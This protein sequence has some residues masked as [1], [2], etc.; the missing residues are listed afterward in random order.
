MKKCFVIQPFDN[1]KYDSRYSETFKPAIKNAGYYAYR[2]DEDPSV[3]VPIQDIEMGI[4]NSAICFAEISTDNPNVWY[5]LG[6]AFACNKQVIMVSCSEERPGKF[7]FD[8]QHKKVI[9]YSNSS[10]GSYEKLGE[11]IKEAIIAIDTKIEIVNPASTVLTK[12]NFN[13]ESI[14]ITILVFIIENCITTDHFVYLDKLVDYMEKLGY[15]KMETNIAFRSLKN[16]RMI[17]FV[18]QHDTWGNPVD[19]HECVLTPQ[20]ENWILS[21]QQQLKHK[22]H[23][24]ID[25]KNNDDI[26]F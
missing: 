4:M 6:Y 16:K 9:S 3:T 17:D 14:E 8:I 11:K 12:E 23:D 2:V 10:K 5:E 19:N 20:G 21:N 18:K 7:P 26:P 1:S 25:N 15:S 24:V 22:R 13:L